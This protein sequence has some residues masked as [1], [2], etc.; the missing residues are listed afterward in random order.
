M[1]TPKNGKSM[2]I[3]VGYDGSSHAKAAIKLICD[4]PLAANSS[5][6]LLGVF[7]PRQ[8]SDHELLRASIEEAGKCLQER[9]LT[10]ANELILGH[11]AE[12]LIEYAEK[13]QPDLLVVG[14]KGLRAT[15]GI[16]LGG[17]A[18]QVVEYANWPVL[19]V[20]E[21]YHPIKRVLLVTDGSPHSQC[22]IEYTCELPL[23]QGIDLRVLHVL[24][25]LIQPEVIA[26]AWPATPGASLP[27]DLPTLE[28]WRLEEE[29]QGQHLLEHAQKIL[30]AAGLDCGTVMRRGDAATE[31]QEY[32]RQFEP[33]LIIAGSRG[34][35]QVRSWLL[36]SVSRKLI[37]YSNTS[38]LIVKR[39]IKD[40]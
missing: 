12:K 18:Q 38:V 36:G 23:P 22:A 32:C 34:L 28:T 29:A 7:T 9:G 33:N 11:P 40:A 26:Q 27:P 35:S 2:K 13:L 10:Q 1:Q 25:P 6:F 3:L 19:V 37:H 39:C 21:P 20:R 30:S 4:L 5:V 24:P 14:A 17:I 8:I 16:L 15:L 31:I